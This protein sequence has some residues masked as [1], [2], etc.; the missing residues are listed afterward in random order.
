MASDL[1]P[2]FDQVPRPN[3]TASSASSGLSRLASGGRRE[4]QM[5]SQGARELVA[6]CLGA[7]PN[8]GNG[9]NTQEG[10]EMHGNPSNFKTICFGSST[11]SHSPAGA[12]KRL[13]HHA[14]HYLHAIYQPSIS[15]SS[16]V[17]PLSVLTRSNPSHLERQPAFSITVRVPNYSNIAATAPIHLSHT[18][19]PPPA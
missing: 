17:F 10:N 16:A 8:I 11:A 15:S 5:S 12:I 2:N 9:I 18:G 14:L 13:G 1:Y 4:S 3:A 19:K 6:S 7:I